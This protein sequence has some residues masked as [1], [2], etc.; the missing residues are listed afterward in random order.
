MHLHKTK[1]LVWIWT[2]FPAMVH[3]GGLRQMEE[4]L[5]VDEE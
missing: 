4:V 2:A 3:L 1:P 5:T